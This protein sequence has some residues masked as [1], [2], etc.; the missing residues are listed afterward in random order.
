MLKND[1]EET[2]ATNNY[3]LSARRIEEGEHWEVILI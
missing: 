1:I 2:T 3:P